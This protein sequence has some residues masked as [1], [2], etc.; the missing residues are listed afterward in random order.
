M[1][2]D[3]GIPFPETSATKKIN[4]EALNWIVKKSKKSP[5]TSFAGCRLAKISNSVCAGNG[6]K[7][8]GNAANCTSFAKRNSCLKL[9]DVL[10]I[11]FFKELTVLLIIEDRFTNSGVIVTLT[12]SFKS[13]AVILDNESFIFWILLITSFFNKSTMN[14][15]KIKNNIRYKGIPHFRIFFRRRNNSFSG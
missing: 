10:A 9:L 5:L 2:K 7:T 8:F 4:F 13:P 1:N 6:G 15:Y 3:A 14:R 12:H 11:S